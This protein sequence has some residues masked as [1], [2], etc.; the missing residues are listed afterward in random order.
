MMHT[1]GGGVRISGPECIE[2][3]PQSADTM[4]S[5]SSSVPPK[6]RCKPAI[7]E[8]P[9]AISSEGL[10][11]DPNS[12]ANARVKTPQTS[13]EGVLKVVSASSRDHSRSLKKRPQAHEMPLKASKLKKLQSHPK[14]P[15]ATTSA[16]KS[17]RKVKAETNGILTT[18]N[19]KKHD[20][21]RGSAVISEFRDGYFYSAIVEEAQGHSSFLVAWDDGDPASWVG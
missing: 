15:S 17:P 5:T 8:V 3:E 19:P 16:L 21:R 2:D 10:E 20:V 7:S 12:K 6:K 1:S 9:P 18:L 13:T 11:P 4:T 14:T